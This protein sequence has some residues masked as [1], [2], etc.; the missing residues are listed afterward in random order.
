LLDIVVETV[1][2][3]AEKKGELMHD[4]NVILADQSG[5]ARVRLCE[6]NSIHLNVGP[7]TLNLE[8]AAFMQMASLMRNAVEQLSEIRK[9]RET[10]EKPFL[11]T[12]PARSRMT[13]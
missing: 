5:L 11:T 10:A 1:G 7:V 9:S 4:V 6:C 12:G 8:P 3:G 2:S 13:H